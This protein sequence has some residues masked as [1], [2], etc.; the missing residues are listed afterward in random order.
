[1]KRLKKSFITLIVLFLTFFTV[2]GN[3]SAKEPTTD[4]FNIIENDIVEQ[5]ESSGIEDPV[6]NILLPMETQSSEVEKEIE[7]VYEE[8][9][10]T[11]IDKPIDAVEESDIEE[12]VEGVENGTIED[13]TIEEVENFEELFYSDKEEIEDIELIEEM[14]E[15]L[16][17]ENKEIIDEN[18]IVIEIT[19]KNDLGESFTTAIGFSI[20]DNVVD[21]INDT[22]EET[23]QKYELEVKNLTSEEFNAVL[24]NLN[25]NEQVEINSTSEDIET[26]FFWVPA[27]GI[28][29]GASML[30]LLAISVSAATLIYFA[31][32]GLVNL[33]SGALWVAGKVANEN[34]K[35]K[36]YVHY[37]AMRANNSK[38]I[39]VGPGRTKSKA[40]T[41][42][43]NGKDCWSVGAT[44]ARLLATGASPTG[45]Y[46]YHDPHKAKS[47]VRTFH[48]YH[49]YETTG[50]H[51]FYGG[52]KLW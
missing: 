27:L 35:N 28:F 23:N 39:W 6:V 26:S 4:D 15:E 32:K 44:N 33:V 30:E 52:G 49:P 14:K 46:I 20:G 7:E 10:S 24:T 12:V 45:R 43:K 8:K 1:M 13:L 48:H 19:G 37:E 34:S 11:V 9:I 38:G 42:I 31:S 2:S 40:I 51:S 29:V 21:I 25:T 17:I 22:S 5:L 41:R 18:D 3:V 47:G 36:K 50:A 16:E